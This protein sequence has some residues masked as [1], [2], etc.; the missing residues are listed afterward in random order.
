MEQSIFI[1]RYGHTPDFNLPKGAREFPPCAFWVLAPGLLYIFCNFRGKAQTITL[2][3]CW[4]FGVSRSN[5][6]FF[7]S[8]KEVLREIPGYFEEN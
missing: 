1:G 2:R 6:G 3:G 7:D 4:V 8:D 5:A